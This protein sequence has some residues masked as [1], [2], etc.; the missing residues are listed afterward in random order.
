M[1]ATNIATQA[2]PQQTASPR[3]QHLRVVFALIVREMSATYGR[4]IGGYF[5]AIAQPLGGILLLAIAFSLALR[6]PPLGSSFILFYAT[7]IIPFTVYNAM[8]G[9]VAGVIRANKGLLTYPVVT[10]LDAVIATFLLNL[11]TQS[12]IAVLLFAM[13]IEWLD[14]SLSIDPLAL[15]EGF[16]LA[17]CIGAGVGAVNAV[18]FGFFPTWKNI[19]GV[20]TRPLFISS[21]V[22][23]LF[24]AAPPQFQAILWDNPIV[25][26]IARM[27]MG[28]F[29]EYEPDFVSLAYVAGVSLACF[30]VGAYLMRRHTSFLLEQ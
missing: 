15:L 12:V 5:W 16:F 2:A 20:L 9:G 7:G 23:F 17:A 3:F 18:L 22:I 13:I 25:H 29:G 28:I 14:V 30:L 6:S 26:V 24:E 1:D 8:A 21:T 11:L 4:S 10:V 27:R 19:W